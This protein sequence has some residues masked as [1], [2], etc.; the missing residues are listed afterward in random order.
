MTKKD[1]QYKD[2]S[3]LGQI[4]KSSILNIEKYLSEQIAYN[5]QHFDL[6][7]TLNN[8]RFWELKFQEYKKTLENITAKLPK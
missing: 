2:L 8:I 7:V 1:F 5:K 3:T 4:I 6:K